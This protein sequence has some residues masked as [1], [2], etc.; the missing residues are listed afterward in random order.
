MKELTAEEFD[1]RLRAIQRAMHIFGELTDNNITKAFQA[2][3]EIFAERERELFI[4]AQQNPNSF[5]RYERPQCPDCGEDMF[6]RKTMPND[7]GI[8]TQLVCGNKDCDT[9]LD[10]ELTLDGWRKVLKKK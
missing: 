7:E 5:A 1:D 10:S 2:Y 6:I 4:A 3:Q 9:V 8:N